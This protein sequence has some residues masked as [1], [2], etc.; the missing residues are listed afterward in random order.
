[1]KIV[2]FVVIVE[3]IFGRL[4]RNFY[5]PKTNEEY[6][7]FTQN[8]IDSSISRFFIESIDDAHVMEEISRGFSNREVLR[9]MIDQGV[10]N[11]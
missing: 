7:N 3:N 9:F 11:A 2:K 4:N 1:M 10:L 5:Y 8:M 6:W